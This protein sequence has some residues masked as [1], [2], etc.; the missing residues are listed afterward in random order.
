MT[1]R[2]HMLN[3]ALETPGILRREWAGWEAQ[4]RQIR[5][6]TAGR[7]TVALIGRGSSGNAC[8]FAAY[9]EG[10][11]TGRQPIEFRPWLTTQDLPRA[12]WSD[13]VAYA[14][15]V[16]G[17]STDIA[18]SANWLRHRGALTVGITAAEEGSDIHLAAATDQ[19]FYLRC[20]P[21]VAVP[22]TKSFN[23]QLFAA[24]ALAGL[25]LEQAALQ[26]AAAMEALQ[27]GTTVQDVA[28]FLEGGRLLGW[29][30]R[31]PSLA[32][33]RDAALKLQE[34]LGRAAVA[35]STAE[36]LHGPIAMFHPEDRVLLFSGADEPMDS[37]RAVASS[38]LARGVPLLT[39]GT[40]STREAG[41]PLPLP[42]AR[43]A[44]TAVLAH[45][46]QLVCVELAQRAGVDP[47]APAHLKKV[48]ITM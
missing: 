18:A 25:P 31:G 26:T 10:L 13:T 33:V 29:I 27:K 47:D 28:T 6:A 38:M 23:T 4:A 17:Q 12:D 22:A 3:E 48:T 44:R 32:G 16:S 14:Y 8:A 37:K 24:A 36:V 41:L 15:S 40:D 9:L 39:L 21:E 45:L 34:S 5:A 7:S 2:R 30:A 35:Y 11:A 42:E 43:W 1:H 19:L 46:S 20:G